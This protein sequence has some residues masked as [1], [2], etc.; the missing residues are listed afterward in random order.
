MGLT[1][2]L[3]LSV[4]NLIN[5]II[6]TRDGLEVAT[7]EVSVQGTFEYIL[8]PLVN[9]LAKKVGLKRRYG[10]GGSGWSCS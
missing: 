6:A 7:S 5:P 4:P 9:G 3:E 2:E 1:D 8:F 10:G